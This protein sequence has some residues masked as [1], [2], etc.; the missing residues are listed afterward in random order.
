MTIDPEPHI[1]GAGEVGYVIDGNAQITVREVQASRS[2]C[3]HH[4]SDIELRQVRTNGEKRLF[5]TRCHVVAR[6][7]PKHVLIRE[8]HDGIALAAVSLKV[9]G[10]SLEHPNEIGRIAGAVKLSESDRT[11]GQRVPQSRV[12][13]PEARRPENWGRRASGIVTRDCGTL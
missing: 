8:Y 4:C 12:T 5:H 2:G 11:S 7:H 10:H 3:Q 6:S 13:R 1:R 9:A